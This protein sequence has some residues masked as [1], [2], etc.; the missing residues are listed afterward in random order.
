MREGSNGFPLSLKERWSL[1]LGSP[2]KTRESKATA[3]VALKK[4]PA[5][6]FFFSE[7]MPVAWA[8]GGV[9]PFPSSSGCFP[10]P[11]TERSLSA[12]RYPRRH[13]SSSVLPVPTFF[14]PI[15]PMTNE[16][17]VVVVHEA[18]PTGQHR[19]APGGG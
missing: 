16:R 14:A 9:T 3:L 13:A 1:T 10:L 11:L 6:P 12:F 17:G 15:L 5:L 4:S 18:S 8:A 19:S 7:A 2:W